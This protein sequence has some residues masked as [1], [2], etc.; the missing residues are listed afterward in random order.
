MGYI[1]Y[2]TVFDRAAIDPVW[3]LPWS[4]FL[5][6]YRPR[7]KA[8][9]ELLEWGLEPE[10]TRAQ[11]EDILARRTL[12]WAIRRC[13]PQLFVMGEL[14]SLVSGLERHTA[15]LR[16]ACLDESAIV[17]TLAAARFRDGDVSRSTLRAICKLHSLSGLGGQRGAVRL[18]TRSDLQRALYP[19]QGDQGCLHSPSGA[20]DD[21]D[22][23]L[24]T[25]DTRRFLRFLD[26]CWTEDCPLPESIGP[27]AAR[28]E[29]LHPNDRPWRFR[30]LELA[31]TLRS[32]LRSVS[33]FQTPAMWNETI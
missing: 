4:E 29:H 19:W 18:L 9:I 21:L 32:M 6:R 23:C 16:L 5:R 12:K 27:L 24:G 22:N 13:S 26:R 17:V 8:V 33:R 25:A 15:G 1:R 3:H 2:Y 14:L 10:P 20:I 7:R 31:S 11:V 28:C 30:H